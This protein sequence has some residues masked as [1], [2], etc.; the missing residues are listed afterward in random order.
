MPC[1]VAHVLASLPVSAH[2]ACVCASFPASI[3]VCGWSFSFMGVGGSFRSWVVIFVCGQQQGVVVGSHWLVVV[4][5][6]GWCRRVVVWLLWSR[7]GARWCMSWLSH[8]C[9]VAMSPAAM[10]HLWLVSMKRR[11]GVVLLTWAG[12][13]LAAVIV[14]IALWLALDGGGGWVAWLMVVV[15]GRKKQ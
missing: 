10:W 1:I 9:L 7:H 14:V 13:D 8:R 2:V 3:H 5:P 15:V 4:S 11:G 6:W 12:H